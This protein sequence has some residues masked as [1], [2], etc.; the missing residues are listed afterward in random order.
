MEISVII[1]RTYIAKYN[2]IQKIWSVVHI[3]IYFCHQ[4]NQKV[5]FKYLKPKEKKIKIKYNTVCNREVRDKD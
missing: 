4:D 5:F 2:T 1:R 3:K